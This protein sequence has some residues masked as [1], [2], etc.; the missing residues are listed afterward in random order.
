MSLAA[1]DGEDRAERMADRLLSGIS[2]NALS[3]DAQCPAAVAAEAAA[4]KVAQHWVNAAESLVL[5]CFHLVAGLETFAEQ[6]E[7][8]DAFLGRLVAKRVLSENDVLARLKANGKLA[9][10]AKIGRLAQTLLQES[11]LPLLPAHYSIIYQ[12][13]L[14][15]EEV[16]FDRAVEELSKH[17]EATR[18]DVIKARAALKPPQD[19]A[20]GSQPPAQNDGSAQLFAL[21]L[22]SQDARFFANEYGRVDALDE[23]LRRPPPADDAGFVAIVPILLMGTIELTLM[24]LLGFGAPQGLFFESP[25]HQPEITDREVI[26]V[27]KRGKFRPRHLSAFP[28]AKNV[29]V[30]AESFFPSCVVKVQL[31]AEARADG[32]LSLIGDENWAE[33]PTVR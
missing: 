32:W 14:L 25:V 4:D 12:I 24:P 15:I 16:G 27:A 10:L 20:H 29:L 31:F 11:L 3:P 21:R 22:T 17:S 13:C 5:A 19:T 26:V 23:C 8:F 18:D 7:L 30:L 33:R 2:D 28:S 6:P 9:M 1:N